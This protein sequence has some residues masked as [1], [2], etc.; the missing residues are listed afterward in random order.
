MAGWRFIP[1]M[2]PILVAK[3]P[4]PPEA[5][6]A[7]R[8]AVGRA[9]CKAAHQASPRGVGADLARTLCVRQ[10]PLA[11]QGTICSPYADQLGGCWIMADFDYEAHDSELGVVVMPLPLS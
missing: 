6:E 11:L 5:K 9:W 4:G 3:P 10:E 8:D 2:F 1:P 7:A